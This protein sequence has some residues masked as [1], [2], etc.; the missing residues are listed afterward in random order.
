MERSLAQ[1]H[2]ER[3]GAPEPAST[4]TKPWGAPRTHHRQGGG[5]GG[6][7]RQERRHTAWAQA[8]KAPRAK[9]S[10][11]REPQCAWYM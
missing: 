1:P 4:G 8:G 10:S 7:G 2:T 5:G 6:A 9:Q 3:A 11:T